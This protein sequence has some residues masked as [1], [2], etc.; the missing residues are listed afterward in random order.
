MLQ[1]HEFIPVYFS[2]GHA[3]GNRTVLQAHFPAKSS[4]F[5]RAA[6]SSL[7]AYLPFL[8]KNILLMKTP[9][10]GGEANFAIES[11]Y[12]PQPSLPFLSPI[13][14]YEITWGIN[15]ICISA[16]ARSR[17]LP[18]TLGAT[19]GSPNHFQ[20]EE[21]DRCRCLAGAL[22]FSLPSRGVYTVSSTGEGGSERERV[23]HM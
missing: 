11:L 6:V 3:T 13:L 8:L 17:S 9:R 12:C 5:S 22:D 14:I 15:S 20:L 19:G 10:G 1:E 21:M 7:S 23:G 2:D 16:L 18:R 4:S